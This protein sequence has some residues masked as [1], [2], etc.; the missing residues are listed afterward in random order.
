MFFTDQLVTM[1]AN[2]IMCDPHRV[3]I[4]GPTQLFGRTLESPDLRA[5]MT[6]LMAGLI[7]NGKTS[8]GNVY[9]IE[10]GYENIVKRLQ[11]LGAK[12]EKID[13]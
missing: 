3:I 13:E 1:G 6:L 2:I 5:G 4:S 8:I 7:A 12:I 11:N 10:R 9:Q